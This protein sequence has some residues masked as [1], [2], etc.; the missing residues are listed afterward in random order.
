MKKLS[1]KSRRVIW[2]AVFVLMNAVVLFFTAEADFS[3]D[4][5]SIKGTIAPGNALFLIGAVLC[6]FLV[7]ACETIKYVLM[8]KRLGEKVSPQTAFETA[9]LGKYYDCITPSGAGGQPFQIWFVHSRG[10][11][12]GASSSMPLAGFVTMQYG[13]VII[14]LIV[15]IFNNDAIDSVPIKLAAYAG[16]VM[17][18]L[19]PTMVVIS[20]L[21]PGASAAIVRFFVRLGAKL[22]IVKDPD[23]KIEKTKTALERYSVSLKHIAKSRLLLAELLVFSVLY[24]VALCSIPYFV[25]RTFGGDPGFIKSLCMSVFVYASITIV[26]TPGNSGAAEGSFYLLFSRLDTSGLFWAMLVWRFLCYY[27]FILIGLIIYA[28]IAVGK[29]RN[30]AGRNAA[31]GSGPG[32]IEY[33]EE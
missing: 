21:A 15:F 13:F 7:L 5:P 32:S 25:V 19:V 30:R 8:M 9:A 10:Y 18:S 29:F 2:I 1:V 27:S 6:L 33:E 20:A 17:Y 11:S 31:N 14:A 16:T 23:A 26:P 22:R 4:T 3:K 24:Q 12:S 28:V